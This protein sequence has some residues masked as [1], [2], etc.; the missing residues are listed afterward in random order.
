[1]DAHERDRGCGGGHGGDREPAG[2]ALRRAQ[3][4]P[5]AAEEP[6]VGHDRQALQVGA[7]LDLKVPVGE[8]AH[9]LVGWVLQR[10]NSAG[11]EG[12]RGQPGRDEHRPAEGG[13][14]FARVVTSDDRGK[15]MHPERHLGGTPG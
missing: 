6:Q 15:L 8:V 3:E 9:D 11:L 7:D 4:S 5:E 1:M 14:A 2:P 10:G 12:R 13:D